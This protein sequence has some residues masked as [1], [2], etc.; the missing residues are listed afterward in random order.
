MGR[1]RSA[2]ELGDMSP[3]PL[4]SLKSTDRR[5]IKWRRGFFMSILSH[6]KAML[7][8]PIAAITRLLWAIDRAR[9]SEIDRDIEA[10]RNRDCD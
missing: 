7:V 3:S 10:A 4:N 2:S 1:R 5:W 6:F 8:R 9:L